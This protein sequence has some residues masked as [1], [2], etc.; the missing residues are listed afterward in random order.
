MKSILKTLHLSNVLMVLAGS[1]ILAFGLC[2]I[3][4][5]SGVTEGG[6]LGLTLLLYHWTGLSP[7][8]S[9][10]LLN[11][12]CYLLGWRV[13]GKPF[14]LYSAIAAAFY[15]LCYSLMEPFAPLF[16]SLIA[17]PFASSLVGALFVGIG[18]GLAVRGEGAPCGDDALAMALS[19]RLRCGIQHIYLFSDLSVL[20][21]SLTYIP[22]SRIAYSLLTVVLSG[23]LIGLMQR[24]FFRKGDAPHGSSLS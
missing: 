6:T 10:L 22:L 17:S 13:L 12:S 16:P 4:A 19:H 18:A 9:S 7:A 21:L 1:F 14:L 20:L 11:G 15:A 24:N 3:H 2:N 5:Y 23:Q 8:L